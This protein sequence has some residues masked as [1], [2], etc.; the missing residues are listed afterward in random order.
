MNA[1]HSG[2]IYNIAEG[3]A[4]SIGRKQRKNARFESGERFIRATVTGSLKSPLDTL[5]ERT[6][7]RWRKVV[8]QHRGASL[9]TPSRIAA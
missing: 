9:E 3:W 7:V 2:A 8:E 5:A 1:A 4:I 6:A